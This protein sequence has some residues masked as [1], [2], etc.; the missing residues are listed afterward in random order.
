MVLFGYDQK[1]DWKKINRPVDKLLQHPPTWKYWLIS[2][3]PDVCYRHPRLAVDTCLG[4]QTPAQ[5]TSSRA[6][7]ATKLKIRF[8]FAYKSAVT[9]AARNKASYDLSIR[10]AT[11]DVDDRVL[12]RNFGFRGK[13]KLADKW[14]R[15]SHI[16]ID[17][18][19]CTGYIRI[20]VII[21]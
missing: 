18:Q 10:E 21:L 6:H 17:I 20:Q 7:Y 14:D 16:V 3:L 11:L 15:E 4:N 5:P 8:N 19:M 13:H 12:I 1:R 9:S 2:T